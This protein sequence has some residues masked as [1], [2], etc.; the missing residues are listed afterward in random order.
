[1]RLSIG[2]ARKVEGQPDKRG[3]SIDSWVGMTNEPDAERFEGTLLDS[4]NTVVMAQGD[5]VM[6]KI[7]VLDAARAVNGD[8]TEQGSVCAF[9]GMGL[10]LAAAGG[11]ASP[12]NVTGEELLT[13]TGALGVEDAFG[14]RLAV[15]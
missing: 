1:M 11:G 7:P 10:G 13:W 4:G 3:V 2:P 5:T 15:G 6:L 14:K 9:P 8:G 12:V